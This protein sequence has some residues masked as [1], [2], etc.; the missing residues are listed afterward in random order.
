M[1][2]PVLDNSAGPKC[3]N[4]THCL[5]YS[6]F[7]IQPPPQFSTSDA[8]LLRMKQSRQGFRHAAV[9]NG[10][11]SGQGSLRAEGHLGIRSHAQNGTPPPPHHRCSSLWALRLCLCPVFFWESFSSC[12]ACPLALSQ[13][14][15]FTRLSG[16]G[17]TGRRSPQANPPSQSPLLGQWAD[18]RR[19]ERVGWVLGSSGCYGHTGLCP[20]VLLPC[21]ASG[22]KVFK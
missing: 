13:Y 12:N 17:C 10:E 15:Q 8:D 14:L 22:F 7:L 11:Q 4:H 9:P 2:N 21:K 3:V 16:R 18:A 5:G 1:L 19:P 20:P 6:V